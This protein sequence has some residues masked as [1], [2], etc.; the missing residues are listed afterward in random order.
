M[1]SGN[2]LVPAGTWNWT[3]VIVLMSVYSIISFIVVICLAIYKPRAL[4]VRMTGAR[5][6]QAIREG[7]IAPIL[8]A[9][10]ILCLVLNPLDVLYFYFLP[11]PFVA[12]K[13][14][15]MFLFVT[16][17]VLIGITIGQNKFAT[18]TGVDVSESRRQ[19]VDTGFM[20]G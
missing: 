19:L 11:A 15:G 7:I 14:L 2:L 4:E 12:I 20:H 13:Y 17:Y 5:Y 6:I 3:D 16:N 10:I 1:P 8:F 9:T 18:A